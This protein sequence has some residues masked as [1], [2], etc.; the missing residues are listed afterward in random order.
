MRPF[1]EC[2]TNP[3]PINLFL[4]KN[5]YFRCMEYRR[6]GLEAHSF[7]NEILEEGLQATSPVD[8]FPTN[9]HIDALKK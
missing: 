8:P 5:E 3:A 4:V 6:E 9:N 2:A 1:E 7:I